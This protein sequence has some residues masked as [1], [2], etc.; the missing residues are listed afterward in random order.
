MTGRMKEYVNDIDEQD[1]A[2]DLEEMTADDDQ[3]ILDSIKE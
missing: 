1:D 3:S 2:R